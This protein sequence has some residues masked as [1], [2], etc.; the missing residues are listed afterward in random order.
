MVGAPCP[1][2]LFVPLLVSLLPRGARSTSAGIATL[3]ERPLSLVVE[4]LAG[5][6][7]RASSGTWSAG[8]VWAKSESVPSLMGTAAAA[9]PISAISAL[10]ARAAAPVLLRKLHTGAPRGRWGINKGE[11][12]RRQAAPCNH[13]ATKLLV[14][15]ARSGSAVSSVSMAERAWTKEAMVRWWRASTTV[16]TVG[17]AVRVAAGPPTWG[18]VVSA[19]GATLPCCMVALGKGGASGGG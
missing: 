4:G 15:S 19:W 12:K 7:G 10:V 8:S 16:G 18:G 9:F 11:D 14:S 1:C 3:L 13:R 2:P 17:E 6:A 5:G